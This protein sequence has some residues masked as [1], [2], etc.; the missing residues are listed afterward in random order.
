MGIAN[1]VAHVQSLPDMYRMDPLLTVYEV[2]WEDKY[3]RVG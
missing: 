1:G 2:E 3:L